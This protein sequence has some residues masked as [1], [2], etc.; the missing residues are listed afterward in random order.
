MFEKWLFD[1]RV[2]DGRAFFDLSDSE[3]DQRMDE[4]L[5]VDP[6]LEISVKAHRAPA[7]KA[8]RQKS[9]EAA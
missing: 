3:C 6:N 2:S 7:M 8:V 5:S 1:L 9:R 4:I